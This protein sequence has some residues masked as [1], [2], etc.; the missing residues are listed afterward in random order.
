M[1]QFRDYKKQFNLILIS[2]AILAPLFFIDAQNVADLQNKINQKDGDIASLEREIAIYQAQLNVI[3]E[4]KSSLTGE[5]KKLDLTRKKLLAD[6][7]LTQ[8]KIDKT[9]LT[10]EEL[11]G[12]IGN[13][14]LSIDTSIES[15]KAGIR[16]TN[17]FEGT[18]LISIILSNDNLSTTWNDIDQLM[19]VRDEIRR[20]ISTLKVVKGELED[21]R[22]DTVQAKAKLV[23]LKNQLGAQQ[24]IIV[25]N[26]KPAGWQL[27]KESSG[28]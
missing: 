9:N 3:N 15:I 24:K 13:K 26:T 16:L 6:I 25:Q 2:V 10:I 23:E 4:E 17:E 7:N 1:K 14:E 12:D 28:A 20:N 21:T 22:Y 27:H 11:S 8:N 18:S 5:I 19:T